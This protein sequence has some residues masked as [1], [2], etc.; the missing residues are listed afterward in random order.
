[1]KAGDNVTWE[2]QAGGGWT[3]K[4]GTV[5]A[6]VPAGEDAINYLPEA[7]AK[8][9]YIKF[10]AVSK[11]DRVLVAVPAGKDGRITHYYCPSRGV[12]LAQGNE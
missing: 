8:K 12:L 6:E 5:V 7:V 1:M 11:R 4:N 2:S 10:Q 9:S 3:E